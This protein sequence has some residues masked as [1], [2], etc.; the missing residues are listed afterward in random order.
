MELIMQ[1]RNNLSLPDL[2]LTGR[3]YLGNVN[4]Q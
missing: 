2:V 4:G 1:L 3:S